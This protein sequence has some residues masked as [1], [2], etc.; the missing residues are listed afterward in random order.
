VSWC[1]ILNS[2]NACPG[3]S[4]VETYV[5]SLC[6]VWLSELEFLVVD[7]LHMHTG[8]LEEEELEVVDSSSPRSPSL[9]AIQCQ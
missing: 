8:D 5:E 6:P 4:A 7:L 2:F 9:T 3:A 1:P